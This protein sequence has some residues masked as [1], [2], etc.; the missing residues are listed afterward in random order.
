MELRKALRG[1]EAVTAVRRRY[2][3][4]RIAVFGSVARDEANQGSDLDLLVEF[5]P[6]A[7]IGL[8]EF[9]RLKRALSEIVGCEADLVTAEALRVEMRDQILREAVYAA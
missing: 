3:V 5:E 2:S 8:F 7:R 4:K 9:V 6:G 1:L